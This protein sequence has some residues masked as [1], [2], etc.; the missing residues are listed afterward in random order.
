M[1]GR[2]HKHIAHCLQLTCAGANRVINTTQQL[3]GTDSKGGARVLQLGM[4]VLNPLHFPELHSAYFTLANLTNTGR[5]VRLCQATNGLFHGLIFHTTGTAHSFGQRWEASGQGSPQTGPWHAKACLTALMHPHPASLRPCEP[6]RTITPSDAIVH[7]M[8]LPMRRNRRE[9]RW[10]ARAA[11]CA[12]APEG[13]AVRTGSGCDCISAVNQASLRNPER[14]N[15]P[16]TTYRPGDGT[17][18]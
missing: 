2:A 18:E 8:L 10:Q 14:R 12:I 9:L 5:N 1:R 11:A 16:E 3:P 17:R 13:V 4:D 6:V 15:S 7:A